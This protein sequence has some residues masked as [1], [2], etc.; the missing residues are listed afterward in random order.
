MKLSP[1]IEL[2]E[3][4]LRALLERTE[5]RV[6]PAD[7]ATIEALAKKACAANEMT[8]LLEQQG[9]TI[10]TL[11]EM[12]FGAHSEK[13]AKVLPDTARQDDHA[14]DDRKHKG[15]G[16]HAAS[17]YEGAERVSVPHPELA[18]GNACPS[19]TKG[20]VYDL[21]PLEAVHVVGQAPLKA[22]VYECQR[23][24]C[25]RCGEVF[26]TQPPEKAAAE[27]YDATAGAALGL[28]KYGSGLPFHRMQ[29]L[30]ESVGVPLPASTQWEIV[31]HVAEKITPAFE[32]LVRQAAQGEVLHNDDTSMTIL[33]LGNGTEA[34]DDEPESERTGVFTTG[35]VS[36]TEERPQIALFF[37]GT[38][39]AGENVADILNKRREDLEPPIQMCD[40]LSRNLPKAFAV[41]LGNC[42]AHARRYFVKIVDQFPEQCRYLLEC[43]REVYK[44]DAMAKEQGMSPEQRLTFHQTHS[45]PVM[46]QLANWLKA[47]FA[48]KKCEPNS[49][50]GN[51]I[52]YMQ[53]HWSEL[54]LFLR[55]PNA[56]LDNN[57]CERALKLAILHRKNA[58]F[59]KTKRGAKVGDIF[60]SLIHTS[61]LCRA[62]AFHYLTELI[63]HAPD[64]KQNPASWLPWNYRTTLETLDTS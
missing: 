5:A 34:R 14:A 62:N 42:L 32:E 26:S 39:H 7:F 28:L 21:S 4:Q 46:D 33:S 18:A 38:K 47:Q 41:I 24:R 2:S 61:R 11:R 19:C 25:N 55:Q 10:E 27:K 12:L 64:V 6:D 8:D 13:T 22:T 23:L 3:D 43:L 54:T 50:L 31:A 51:A 45:A 63:R 44:H 48:E 36:T 40:A 49:A 37:T 16:R 30:H 52:S 53:K 1:T 60:M 57:I 56:P 58:L 29:K 20:K 15:H 17:S 35:I 59:F 9:I